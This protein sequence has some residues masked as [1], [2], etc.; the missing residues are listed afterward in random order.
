MKLIAITGLAAYE[1]AQLAQDMAHTMTQEGQRV[2]IIDNSNRKDIQPVDGVTVERIA[3]GCV[4]CSLPGKLYKMMAHVDSD[5]V[6]LVTSESAHPESLMMVLD[7]LSAGQAGLDIQTI[8][9]ID[10][11][12]C[13]CFPH[14]HEMMES[15]N[16]VTLRLPFEY[17][18]IQAML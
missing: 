2:T 11:R 3:G 14:L 18:E 5:A 13:D 10:D 4:C 7:N 9:V 16:D 6:L 1:K 12:T 8:G 17:K 15:Y